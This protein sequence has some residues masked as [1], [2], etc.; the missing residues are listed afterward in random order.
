MKIG[1]AAYEYRNH[2]ID[3][4][5]SQME[6]ALQA[7][8]GK[9]EIVCFGEAFLQ[10]FDALC[11]E[12]ET[13]QDVAITR[14]SPMM[15]CIC[16]MTVRYGVDLAFG[17]FEL[18]GDCIYSAY[19]VVE[20]GEILH[21]YR[22]ITK[23][24]KEYTRT[25][26]HYREGTEAVPFQYHG[27]SCTVALCGDLWI[28]PERFSANDLLIWPIYVNFSL[29]DWVKEIPAYAKQALLACKNAVMI[30]SITEA[31]PSHGNSFFFSEAA[32]KDS[33]GFDREGILY[34]AL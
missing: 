21:N 17:Y 32:V 5:L 10:G 20:K 27:R 30:N 3:F 29:R 28:C 19:A 7:A 1:L 16:A 24:W 12:F 2:D 4:N 8:Q 26:R 33:L 18:D 23:N 25:D 22:R 14:N 9:A 34:L 13:D 31:P 15:A 6:R 11:W